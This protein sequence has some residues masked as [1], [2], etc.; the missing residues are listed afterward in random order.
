M[1]IRLKRQIIINAYN[2]LF[3]FAQNGDV[4][5]ECAVVVENA[6]NSCMPGSEKITIKTYAVSSDMT[7]SSF[8]MS[9]QLKLNF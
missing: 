4:E 9:Q 1:T 6:P 2:E 3:K 8:V 7:V 5:N